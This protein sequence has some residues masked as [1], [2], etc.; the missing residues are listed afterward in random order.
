MC[1]FALSEMRKKYLLVKTRSV[2]VE[3][4]ERD[5]NIWGQDFYPSCQGNM[6]GSDIVEVISGSRGN[7]QA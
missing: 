6:L 4:S 2:L 7:I 5:I 3:V 1:L